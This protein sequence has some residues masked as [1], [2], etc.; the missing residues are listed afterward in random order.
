MGRSTF[1][2]FSE[3]FARAEVSD[4]F[5]CVGLL[6]WISRQLTN[7]RLPWQ[8]GGCRRSVVQGVA[9]G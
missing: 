4:G 3:A 6:K 8:R 2:S 1:F 7:I 9:G 5:D